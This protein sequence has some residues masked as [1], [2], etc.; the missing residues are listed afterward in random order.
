MEESTVPK[1]T[2]IYGQSKLAGT[3]ALSQIV[4]RRGLRAIC[5]RPFS[6]FGPGEGK[7]GVI[8]DLVRAAEGVESVP[9]SR[10]FERRDFCHLEEAARYVLALGLVTSPVHATGSRR[11]RGRRRQGH[12]MAGS[13]GQP[14]V[15]VKAS[16][17][18]AEDHIALGNGHSSPEG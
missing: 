3:R 4:E 1:P 5:V 12:A 7:A 18:Y 2:T 15:L 17:F 14:I 9:L 13:N 11:R 6:L 8:E 10:G 16:H